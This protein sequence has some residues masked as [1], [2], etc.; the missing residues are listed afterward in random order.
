MSAIIFNRARHWPSFVVGGKTI[1]MT[2]PK[3]AMK[4]LTGSLDE[5]VERLLKLAMTLRTNCASDGKGVRAKDIT[6]A[7]EAS[8]LPKR[9]AYL[10]GNVNEPLINFSTAKALI[11]DT[12]GD[13]MHVHDEEVEVLRTFITNYAID[14][15]TKA[16][17]HAQ[18]TKRSNGLD[19]FVV[20]EAHTML[21]HHDD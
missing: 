18:E 20:S 6:A 9:A 11:K 13:K 14:L 12:L 8:Y 4:E 19:E 7:V 17:N 16:R 1:R 10:L 2:I 5:S 21:H 15:I 3:T